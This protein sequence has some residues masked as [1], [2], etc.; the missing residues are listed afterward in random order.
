MLIL[1]AVSG[2]IMKNFPDD[3][4]VSKN[5]GISVAKLAKPAYSWKFLFNKPEIVRCDVSS[6]T[7]LRGTFEI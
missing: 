5:K 6:V 7:Y 1:D 2:F 4:K 3:G